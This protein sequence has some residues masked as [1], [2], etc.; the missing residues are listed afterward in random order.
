MEPI[1][2]TSEAI[3]E[4]GPLMPGGEDTLTQ[5]KAIAERVRRVV[6][7][8]VGMSL[9]LLDH[10]VTLTLVAS[11]GEI[12]A[13]DGVQYLAGGPCVS[14]VEDNRV[15]EYRATDVLDEATWRLFAQVTAEAGI[16]STLTLPIV[17]GEKAVGS[18]NLYATTPDAFRDRHQRIAAIVGAWASGAVTNADR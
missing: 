2:E 6:P 14:A 10:G 9:A 1:P 7:E 15:V 17:E 16:A 12:A 8:C 4:Y 3:D 18:V 5:L 11:E 13:L